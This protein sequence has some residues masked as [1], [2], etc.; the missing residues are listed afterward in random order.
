MT[1][2]SHDQVSDFLCG[3]SKGSSVYADKYGY[4]IRLEERL[5]GGSHLGKT[6]KVHPG[7][8]T[9]DNCLKD[10]L[11]MIQDSGRKIITI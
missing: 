8:D 9:L 2:I 6:L 10:C 11:A 4:V 5:N 3:L 1:Q 7:S